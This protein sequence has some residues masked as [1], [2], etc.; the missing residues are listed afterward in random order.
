VI[1]LDNNATTRPSPG[2]CAAAE[3]A[4]R[5]LWHNPSSVHRPGLAARRALELARASAAR[6]I[7]ARPREI[8]LTSGGTESIELAVR[9]ALA[10]R[11]DLTRPAVVTTAVEHAAVRDLIE[12]LAPRVEVRFAP[13]RAGG[14]VDPASLGALI[15]GAAALVS[16]QWANNETGAVQPI[17]EIGAICRERGV[18]LHA[19]A[20]QW[21][22][23]MPTR[24]GTGTAPPDDPAHDDHAGAA[25]DLLTFS[26]HK[27]HGP[28]G[29]GA[30]FVRRGTRLASVRPGAQELGRRGGTENVPGLLGMG[31]ACD[32]A[33]AFLAD[34]SERLR[35]AGLRDR[36]E[37]RI[38][39]ACPAAKVNGPSG[40]DARLWNTTNIGFPG[41]EAEALLLMLSERGVCASAGAAC[42]SGSLEPSPVLLAMGVEPRY[43]HGSIRLSLSRHS[44]EAEVDQA[45]GIIAAAASALAA[46]LPP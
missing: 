31:A 35:L 22:G 1:Y 46:A 30:L 17:A 21:V 43:A 40:R 41:L 9:G 15:D 45:A 27:L 10:A 12:M 3:Q 29:A 24:V 2:A 13:L 38:L 23:K 44:T 16:V 25:V 34:P 14:V 36:L 28:K 11:T 18:P 19:D 20:T 26:A 42:S 37:Q 5:E 7:D 33:R 4:L 8:I 6:L 32:E 39:T